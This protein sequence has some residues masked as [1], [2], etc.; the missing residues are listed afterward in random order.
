M[1][2]HIL[3]W[4]VGRRWLL[5]QLHQESLGQLS[6]WSSSELCLELEKNQQ[7][8]QLFI[9]KWL[10]FLKC[11]TFKHHL[12]PLLPLHIMNF[13][14][15]FTHQMQLCII[16]PRY[17]ARHQF[18]KQHHAFFASTISKSWDVLLLQLHCEL[19]KSIHSLA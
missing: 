2:H 5:W 15:V 10:N 14:Y 1:H 17:G 19:H 16:K 7:Y 13:I 4:W 3:L 8:L 18:P 11:L 9:K 12:K 6:A